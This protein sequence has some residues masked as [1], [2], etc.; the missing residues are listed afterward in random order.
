M[1]VP[2]SFVSLF[3]FFLADGDSIKET[4]NDCVEPAGG[5]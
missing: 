3:Y 5:D 4:P 2:S 1:V